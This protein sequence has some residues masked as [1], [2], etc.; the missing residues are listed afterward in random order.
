ML[1]GCSE[2]AEMREESSAQTASATAAT[3]SETRTEEPPDEPVVDESDALYDTAPI[4]Q[5]Y[6]SGDTSGLDEFQLEIYA[7]AAA[8][9][10]EVVTDGMTDYD[11]ELAVHDY[12]ITHAEYDMDNIGI[13]QT[14]GKNAENPYGALA[15]G[16]CICSGYTTTFQMFMDMLEIPC[17]SIKAT[18]DDGDDHAWNMVKINGHWYYVDVTWDDPV[19]DAKDRPLQHKYFNVSEEHMAN[20]HN[21]D[22][23]GEPK[24]DSEEDSY[25]AHN[26][27][28]TEDILRMLERTLAEGNGNVFFEPADPR[29]WSLD[30]A[31][32]FDSYVRSSEISDELTE[33]EKA[34]DE[35]HGEYFL[36]WQRV[37]FEGKVVVGIYI[38][39]RRD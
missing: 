5:A 24:T 20:R 23:S 28:G 27:H 38:W 11:K 31:D 33:V 26:L 37:G 9:T 17:R 36:R 3:S 25:I 15:E 14:H 16:K 4:S 39:P 30:T 21:W 1:S 6:L 18:S 8:V 2:T 22:S 19:P 29:G 12:I 34:F 32:D 13:F 35:T 7:L 10:D